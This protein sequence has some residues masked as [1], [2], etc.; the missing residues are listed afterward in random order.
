MLKTGALTYPD[1]FAAKGQDWEEQQEK[2]AEALGLSVEDY[3][4][5]LADSILGPVA[6]VE[7]EEEVEQD[8]D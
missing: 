3:R 4:A 1:L 8:E 5:R 6:A 2:Q 7:V